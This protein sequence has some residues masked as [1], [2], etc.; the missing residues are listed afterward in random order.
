MLPLTEKNKIDIFKHEL[1]P[2]HIR[3]T[4]DETREVLER[5]RIQPYQLPHIELSD[6]AVREIKAVP[7]D[8]I[9]I[10]R[11]SPTAGESIAYRYVVKG[12]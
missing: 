1:V 9:K 2:K 10:I 5:Y 6:P 3:L 11:K 4:P 7:G 8:V 12:Q